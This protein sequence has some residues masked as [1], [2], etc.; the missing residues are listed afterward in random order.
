MFCRSFSLD[1][2]A[3]RV[4]LKVS[5]DADSAAIFKKANTILSYVPSVRQI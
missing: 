2:G 5:L 3:R 4:Y 1:G